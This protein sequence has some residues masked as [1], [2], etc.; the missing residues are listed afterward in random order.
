MSLMILNACSNIVKTN[1]PIVNTCPTITPCDL[2]YYDIQTNADLITALLQVEEDYAFC[3]TK[4]QI[5]AECQGRLNVK[6]K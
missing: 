2:R 4:V 6:T 3:A 5:I 1:L